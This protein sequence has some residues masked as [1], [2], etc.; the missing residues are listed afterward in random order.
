MEI[1]ELLL[2]SAEGCGCFLEVAAF[3]MDIFTGVRGY[4]VGRKVK[5]RREAIAHGEEP[6]KKPALWPL[7][8]LV[9]GSV[10]LTGLVLFKWLR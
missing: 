10:A 6:P 8:L 2:A 7:V 3:L 5:E 1:I 9:L 4:Q